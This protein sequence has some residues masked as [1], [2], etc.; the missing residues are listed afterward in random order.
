MKTVVSPWQDPA[1]GTVRLVTLADKQDAYTQRVRTNWR[2]D[3]EAYLAIELL[4]GKTGQVVDLGA[5][6]G[7][8]C[9][10]VALGSGAH[11][12]AVE[13]LPDNAAAL[14]AAIDE[15]G[16]SGRVT[17][18]QNA[19]MDKRGMVRFEGDSAYGVVSDK[20]T[21]EV[22]ADSLDAMAGA[23]AH[24][25][26]LK[27]DIEGCERIA[28]QGGS[29]T[30]ARTQHVMFEGNGAHAFHRGHMPQDLVA[31]LEAH[32]FKCYM[33]NGRQLAP[34]TSTSFQPLGLVNYFATRASG[35]AFGSFAVADFIPRHAVLG[36]TRA[37]FD[38]K[39]GYGHFMR[40]QLSSGRIKIDPEFQELIA[41][42]IM[43]K[44]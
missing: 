5:N 43:P 35:N 31:D 19:I 30:L 38:M 22:Q 37:L 15:N 24:I 11:V 21:T 10:P 32:G 36:V 28:L 4:K 1:F 29:R 40:A 3:V 13:A 41:S 25:D 8:W 18:M 23:L 2:A 7:T 9:L 42:T 27:M 16:L 20:G 44:K 33:V 34:M 39:P 14:R 6:I 26:V 12:L 17:V